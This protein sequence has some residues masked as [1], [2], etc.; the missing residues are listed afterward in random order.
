[1]LV[2]LG[3]RPWEISALVNDEIVA[4][5][6]GG[7]AFLW[8]MRHTACTEPHYTLRDLESLDER[9]EANLEGLQVAAERGWEACRANLENLSASEVFALSAVAFSS[10]RRDWMRDALF[11]ACAQPDLQAGLVSAL[12][13][14]PFDTVSPWLSLLLR[15]AAPEHR[16]I[17]IAAHAIHRRDPGS[18]LS[19]ALDDPDPGLRSRALRA[20][21]ELRRQDLLGVLRDHL[22]DDVSDCRFWS[23]W[24]ATLLGGHDSLSDLRRAVEVVGPHQL[25]ALELVVRA[26]RVEESRSWVS[27]I[28]RQGASLPVIVMA[29]GMVG[30]PVAADWLIDRMSDP[31]LAKLAGEAFSSMCG[32]DLAL[33]DLVQDP[34]DDQPADPELDETDSATEPETGVVDKERQRYESNLP[35]P[36]PPLVAAWWQ[37]NRQ[38]FTAGT[39]YLCGQPISVQTARSVLVGGKQRQRRAAAFEL[40]CLDATAPFYE[41]RA[42]GAR[43]IAQ[44]TS[45]SQ[46]T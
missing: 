25:R 45:P 19:A 27:A 43:Q 12:G 20:V 29:I 2:P 15:S 11:T 26:M 32:V 4:R 33:Q 7:A 5:H 30:D 17:A 16:R 8:N 41:V 22:R 13:W 38:R 40:A 21:G 14:L 28:A 6:A 1:M 37:K 46:S 31:L 10:N 44:L 34:H 39:R 35:V 42:K 18:P 24:S 9:V 3:F 36:A 23:A